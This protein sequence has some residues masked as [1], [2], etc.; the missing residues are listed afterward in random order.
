MQFTM[1]NVFGLVA[2][3]TIGVST[4]TASPTQVTSLR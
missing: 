3:L 1:K 2:V 4:V